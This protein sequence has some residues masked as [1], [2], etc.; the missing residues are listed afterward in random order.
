MKLERLEKNPILQPRGDDWESLAVFNGG[1]VLKDGNIHLFYRAIGEYT[2]YISNIGHAV[3]GPDLKL[4]ER[5][6][7][8]CFKP[9]FSFWEKSVED[10]RIT[11]LDGKYY[12]TYVATITPCPPAGVRKRLGIPKKEQAPTRIVVAET[13][14]FKEFKRL[15]YLTP[16]DTDQR[17]TV[18]FPEK[19]NGRIAVLHRPGNWIGPEYGTDKPAIWFAYLDRW[20][21]QLYDH[22]LV[23]K[24]EF[25]WE[26]YK[27]GAGP[28]PIK[29]EK[30]WL[31]IYHGVQLN[32]TYRA[33]AALLD[34]EE[35]W[36]VIARTK[37]P[38]LEPEMKYECIGDMPNVVF[39]QGMVALGDEL[40]VF[41]GG[42]DKVVAASKV[43]L[44][45]FINNLIG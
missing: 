41:Y 3:F 10:V 12:M 8:P 34:L 20:G 1:A 35:P 7:E 5:S 39:P 15:G 21:T 27:I 30:G 22:K 13:E 25:D 37:E 44:K 17:D 4:I 9:D 19:I 16:Y 18:I 45:E 42:A 14:D 2:N 11:P 23:M 29:T 43:N 28:P 26:S 40:I 38:I 32:R 31:L 33:G 36:K 6:S 24:S